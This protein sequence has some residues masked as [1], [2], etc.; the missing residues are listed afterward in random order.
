[1]SLPVQTEDRRAKKIR[2]MIGPGSNEN[3]IDGC[4]S[5]HMKPTGKEAIMPQQTLNIDRME[6]VAIL[7]QSNFFLVRSRLW[8][9]I[10]GKPQ[11]TDDIFM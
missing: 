11:L 8:K 10:H 5:D 3:D 1:M 9:L 7:C 4:A 2:V 6:I